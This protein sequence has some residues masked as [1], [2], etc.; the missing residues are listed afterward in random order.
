MF[1]ANQ[2]PEQEQNLVT[3]YNDHFN[4]LLIIDKS[5]LR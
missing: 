4:T 5:E 1:G 3:E 2:V